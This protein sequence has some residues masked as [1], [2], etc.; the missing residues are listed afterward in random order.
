M[1]NISAPMLSD[2]PTPDQS[3]RTRPDFPEISDHALIGD[4]RT[5]ALVT[6]NGSIDWL[7]LPHFS[8]PSIFACLLDPDRGGFCAVSPSAPFVMRRSYIEGSAALETVFEAE[9]GTAVLRDVIPILDGMSPLRPMRGG[10]RLH[11]RRKHARALR[12]AAADRARK[13]RLQGVEGPR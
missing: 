8:S 9:G 4:C 13:N 7:C 1:N 11:R 6:R 12:T 3:D 10:R 2:M 5:A